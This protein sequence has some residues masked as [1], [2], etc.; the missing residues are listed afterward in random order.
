MVRFENA[1]NSTLSKKAKK[2]VDTVFLAIKKEKS[3]KKVGYYS[4]PQ[5][6]K[7]LLKEI[8]VYKKNNPFFSKQE[9]NDI[10][11]MGIGGS[12]LGTKAIYEALKHQYS[13]K[14]ELHFL[15]NCDSIQI[16]ETLGKIKKEKT[17]FMVISKSGTTIETISIFKHILEEYK[18][19]LSDQ[20]QANQFVIITD[21]GSSLNAFANEYN[22]QQFFIPANVGGRFSVLSAVGVVPLSLMEFDVKALLKGA[23]EFGQSFFKKEQTSL[24]H[25]AYHYYK[26]IN[27]QPINVMF[28]Y[29]TRLQYFNQWY[30]QLWG[31]SLGKK[32]ELDKKVGL[33][34]IGLVGSVDQ[35]SFLQLIIQG[36][37]NKTVTFISID[38]FG[39]KINIPKIKLPHLE[40]CDFANGSSFTKLLNAQCAATKESLEEEGIVVDEIKLTTLD[41][42]NV[43]TLICYYEILTSV[44]G[45]FLKIN[46]Y[47]QPGVEFGKI[48]LVKKFEKR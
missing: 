8:N 34:P 13:Q 5:K 18:F 38:D 12:T 48:K 21:E 14:R 31:E 25:K 23:K 1:F 15:E 10:V 39:K 33:T 2:R 3:E 28:T 45:K 46:T 27:K 19:D 24:L 7:K 16:E 36:P 20:K 4:L 6:S 22:I 29:S 43:G 47:D 35:H 40:K 32:N 44:M 37:E 26:N 41:E 42:K 11:I 17:L 30:V 9:I